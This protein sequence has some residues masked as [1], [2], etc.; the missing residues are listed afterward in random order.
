MLT[1]TRSIALFSSCLALAACGENG[2]L[3]IG[4]SPT[5]MPPRDLTVSAVDRGTGDPVAGTTLEL[6]GTSVTT[7]AKG[8]ATL[9]ALPGAAVAATAPGSTRQAGRCRRAATW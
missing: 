3:P 6:G 9:T 5:P 2:P 4:G 8:S 1:R 7:D